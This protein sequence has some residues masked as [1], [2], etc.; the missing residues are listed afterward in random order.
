MRGSS[1]SGGDWTRTHS[2][3]MERQRFQPLPVHTNL[4]RG[5]AVESMRVLM[6]VLTDLTLSARESENVAF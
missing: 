2:A 3:C 4:Q 5:G 1:A 6:D